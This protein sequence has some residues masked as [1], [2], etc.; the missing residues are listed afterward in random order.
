MATNSIIIANLPDW[1]TEITIPV[2]GSNGS[3]SETLP[4]SFLESLRAVIE[5]H[6]DIVH[7]VPVRRFVCCIRF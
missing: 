5:V 3:V 7:W 1:S 4:S 2:H 6:R